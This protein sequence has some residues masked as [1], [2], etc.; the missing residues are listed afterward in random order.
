MSRPR[1][2]LALL[3]ILFLAAALGVGL[4]FDRLIGLG[5]FIVGAFLLILPFLGIHEEE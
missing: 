3:G 5:V 2:F 4:V 1:A